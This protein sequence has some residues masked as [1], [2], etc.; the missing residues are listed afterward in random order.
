MSH[1]HSFLNVRARM[2]NISAVI[3]P[4]LKKQQ[5][6]VIINKRVNL[7]KAEPH[8]RAKYLQVGF[9]KKNPIERS[10]TAVAATDDDVNQ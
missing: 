7:L 2:C 5:C 8:G 9:F 6:C 4:V 3:L 1:K 10:A